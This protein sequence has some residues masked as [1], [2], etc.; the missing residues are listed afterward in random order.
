MVATRKTEEFRPPFPSKEG[1]YRDATG[2]LEKGLEGLL[3]LPFHLETISLE[4]LTDP[5]Q[6]NRLFSFSTDAAPVHKG[7]DSGRQAK[8][9]G[10]KQCYYL[11]L[12]K[13]G[14]PQSRRDR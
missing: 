12:S 2:G 11:L 10:M 9:S 13:P 5:A 6:P 7:E 1:E 14:L 3:F 4:I 8:V